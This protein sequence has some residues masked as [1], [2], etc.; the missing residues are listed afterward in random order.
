MNAGF[1]KEKKEKSRAGTKSLGCY[2]RSVFSLYNIRQVAQLTRNSAEKADCTGNTWLCCC[3]AEMKRR[4]KCYFIT[5][6]T[7]VCVHSFSWLYITLHPFEHTNH[8]LFKENTGWLWRYCQRL[9]SAPFSPFYL[10][11][12]VNQLTF[13]LALLSLNI[14]KQQQIDT[15]MSASQ[16]TFEAWSHVHTFGIP[17]SSKYF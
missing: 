4:M 5:I 8:T 3:C 2:H 13:C 6:I 12:K 11:K 7:N 15:Q 16:M 9:W 14:S 1:E 17:A 10:D